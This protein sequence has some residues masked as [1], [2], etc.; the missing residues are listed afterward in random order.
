[1]HN[2]SRGVLRIIIYDFEMGGGKRNGR[3][4]TENFYF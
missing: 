2:K 3:E 1:M 4:S